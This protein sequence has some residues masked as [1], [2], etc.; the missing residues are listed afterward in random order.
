MQRAELIID[1]GPNASV[2]ALRRAFDDVE[3]VLSF[4]QRVQSVLNRND[5]V[6]AVVRQRGYGD[7]IDDP[8]AGRAFFPS[9]AFLTIWGDGT[10]FASS[11]TLQRA[12]EQLLVERAADSTVRI[13]SL[14]YQNPLDINFNFDGGAIARILETIRDWGARREQANAQARQANAEAREA[15]ARADR[16]E[17]RVQ[18]ERAMHEEILRSLTTGTLRLSRDQV[19]TLLSADVPRAI[20]ALLAADMVLEIDDDDTEP[21]TVN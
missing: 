7:F 13:S 15:N 14:S 11:P 17:D 10:P 4:A 19:D 20:G 5:A 3:T 21:P 12:V 9:L 2:A 6:Y 18:F 16:Y 1:V 8:E